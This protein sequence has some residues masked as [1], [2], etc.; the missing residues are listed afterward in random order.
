LLS[1]P[2]IVDEHYGTR[3]STVI[4]VSRNGAVFFAERRFAPG[5]RP[6]GMMTE[7]FELKHD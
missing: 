3:C 4:L 1:S 7:R 2:F 5:G 6:L